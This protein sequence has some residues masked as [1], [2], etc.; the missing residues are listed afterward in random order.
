MTPA[1]FAEIWSLR[2]LQQRITLTATEKLEVNKHWDG[3]SG[4][5][6]FMDAFHDLWR[7]TDPAGHKV[8]FEGKHYESA[9]TM[10]DDD[11]CDASVCPMCGGECGTLGTLGNTKYVRCRR[12][13]AT[14][15]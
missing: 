3:L 14:T 6:S 13:G 15:T 9:E 7:K 2:G 5:T 8:L 1:R 11:E 4:S 10:A 12:C